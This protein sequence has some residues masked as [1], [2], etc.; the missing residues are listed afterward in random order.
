MSSRDRNAYGQSNGWLFEYAAALFL[1]IKNVGAVKEIGLEKGEDIVIKKKDD[2][3]IVAQAKSTVVMEDIYRNSQYDNIYKS[4]ES[5]SDVTIEQVDEYIMINN[6]RKPF[7][8][9]TMFDLSAKEEAKYKF[10]NLSPET[11]K[12]LKKYTS[13]SKLN[14][15]FDRLFYYF[16]CFESEEPAFYVKKILEAKLSLID[17]FSQAKAGT[18]L[19]KWRTLI[20]NNSR[21]KD[22]MTD[23]GFFSGALFSTII[24]GS[25]SFERIVEFAGIDDDVFAS[26]H[27]PNISKFF[28]DFSMTFDIY[29]DICVDFNTYCITNNFNNIKKETYVSYAQSIKDVPDYFADY[30]SSLEEMLNLYRCFVVYVIFKNKAIDKIKEI[31]GY[32]N[33]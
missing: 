9:D 32:D 3:F 25:I 21:Q 5:L 10:E 16:L 31:F 22:K 20:E 12:K 28:D 1:F 24:N 15:D 17:N 7:G 2:H 4:L 29:T 8:A 33:Q 23:A 13:E 27:D 6:Y 19:E 11:K 26:S 30:F 14:I 18:I